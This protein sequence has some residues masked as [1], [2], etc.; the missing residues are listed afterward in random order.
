MK[1]QLD[2]I[3]NGEANSEKIAGNS[4]EIISKYSSKLRDTESVAKFHNL[5]EE[6]LYFKLYKPKIL[7]RYL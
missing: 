5:L 7:P 6:I 4:L 3:Q 2:V 1:N